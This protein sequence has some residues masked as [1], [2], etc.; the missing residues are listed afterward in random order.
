M[1]KMKRT[2]LALT[3]FVALCLLAPTVYA[4]RK[5]HVRVYTVP[6]NNFVQYD[7]SEPMPNGFSKVDVCYNFSWL[8]KDMNY[9]GYALQYVKGVAKAGSGND[10]SAL[11]GYGV[12]HSDVDGKPGTITYKVGNN[13]AAPDVFWADRLKIVEGTGYFEGIKGQGELNFEIFAFE[14]YLD[15][16]PWA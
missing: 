10:F 4:M 8:D 14:L 15:Y 12:Y 6:G 13:W 16:D 9:L 1:R 5:V 7:N 11:H 2:R 3:F